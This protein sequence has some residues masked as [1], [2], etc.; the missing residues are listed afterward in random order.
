M[1]V[2][3]PFRLSANSL[4]VAVLFCTTILTQGGFLLGQAAK[5]VSHPPQRPLPE[6]PNRPLGKGPAWFVDA[7]KGNDSDKGIKDAPWKTINHALAR[8]SPGDTLYLR[9][10]VYFE[11][12][13]CSVVGRK[14]A[15]I[16]IR[17]YPGER[18]VIDGGIREFQETTQSAWQPCPGGVPGEYRSAKP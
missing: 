6:M 9:G 8:L 13:Y 16:T 1:S 18:V 15:P 4:A 2:M 17:S 14:D 10:G 3:N 12:V 11:N 5:Y 7:A